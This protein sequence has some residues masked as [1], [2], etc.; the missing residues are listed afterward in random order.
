[1]PYVQKNADGDVIAVFRWPQPDAIDA[2]GNTCPGV[3]T[4]YVP[5]DDPALMAFL[6]APGG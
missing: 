6:A 2:D 5:D 4:D 1:M 3:P